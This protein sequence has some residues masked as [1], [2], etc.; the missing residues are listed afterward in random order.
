MV[1]R[2]R[3]GRNSSGAS[4]RSGRRWMPLMYMNT[5]DPR[6]SDTPLITAS[7][8]TARTV[9][10]IVGRSRRISVMTASR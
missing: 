9:N 4:Y 7:R 10:R 5:I 1:P 2:K 3:S 6:G 8:V